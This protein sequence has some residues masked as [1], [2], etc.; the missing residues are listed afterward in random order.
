MKYTQAVQLLKNG[1][2]LK[3]SNSDMFIVCKQFVWYI[4]YEQKTGKI[5]VPKGFAT[6]L[7]SIPPLFRPF[8]NRNKYVAYILHDY[9][10]HKKCFSRKLADKIFFEALRVEKCPLINVVLMYMAV[11]IFGRKYFNYK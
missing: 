7:G 11:R 3:V 1:T 10:Y 2:L 4:N 8:F 5:T 9:L 6:D